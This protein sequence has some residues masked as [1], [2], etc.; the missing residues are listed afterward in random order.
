MVAGAE[1]ELFMCVPDDKCEVTEE[2]IDTGLA[3]VLVG[4][5]YE[6]AVG[7]DSGFLIEM[8]I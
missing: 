1:E 6:G 4:I 5:E 8:E 3:P 7:N 2:M